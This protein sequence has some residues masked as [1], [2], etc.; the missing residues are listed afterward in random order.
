M[1]RKNQAWRDRLAG[2][3][4]IQSM[5][6]AGLPQSLDRKKRRMALV[7]VAD[8]WSDLQ[9]IQHA[10]PA[11]AEEYFLSDACLL[12]SAIEPQCDFTLLWRILGQIRVHQIQRNATHLGLPYTDDDAHVAD[13]QGQLQRLIARVASL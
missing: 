3:T 6:L 8:V 5:C 1:R 11:D 2:L 13:G 12:V 4:E 7:H 9:R 10:K